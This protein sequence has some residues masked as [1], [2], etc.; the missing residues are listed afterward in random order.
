MENNKYREIRAEMGVAFPMSLDSKMLLTVG[1]LL[2]STLAA[3]A[4]YVRRGHIR[5]VT[6]PARIF[7]R[8]SSI[9]GG[10]IDSR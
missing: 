8:Q 9:A 7:V 5:E 10:S 1:T 6:K 2:I 3:P 4:A